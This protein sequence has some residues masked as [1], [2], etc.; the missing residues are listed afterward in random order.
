MHLWCQLIP[1]TTMTLNMMRNFRRSPTMLACTALE[2]KFHFNKTPLAQPDIKVIVH[3]TPQEH[4][5][6][7]TNGVPGLYI[8]PSMEHYRCY[9]CYTPNIRGERRVDVVG[10][11]HNTS[12]CHDYQQQN[13]TPRTPNNCYTQSKILDH[14]PFSRSERAT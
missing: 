13:K 6:W 12:L 11:S 10:F 2:G 4:K 1:Q 9:T 5:T 14:K 3:E 7:G 8:R